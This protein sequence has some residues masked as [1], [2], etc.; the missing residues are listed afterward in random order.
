MEK[1][2]KIFNWLGANREDLT[3]RKMG[4]VGLD[5]NFQLARFGVFIDKPLADVSVDTFQ[6]GFVASIPGLDLEKNLVTIILLHQLVPGL[7][8]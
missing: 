7:V 5:Q 4:F 2:R 1:R 3:Y 8:I 6:V